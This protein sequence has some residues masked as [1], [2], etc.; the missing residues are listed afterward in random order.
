MGSDGIGLKDGFNGTG[1]IICFFC[2]KPGH[3][4]AQ[5]RAKAAR[6]GQGG[7]GG[8]RGRRVAT[9]DRGNSRPVQET[10]N[11]L[12]YLGVPQKF[13]TPRLPVNST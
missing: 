13:S 3:R 12:N 10:Q 1:A 8:G 2:N 7:G 11:S 4:I 5:C 6:R 9:V